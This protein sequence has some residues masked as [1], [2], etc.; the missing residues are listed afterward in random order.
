MPSIG[1]TIA[2]PLLIALLAV[3]PVASLVGC[4]KVT[5]PPTAPDPGPSGGGGGATVSTTFKGTAA[6]A[7]NNQSAADGV[8]TVTIV[9]PT[10]NPGSPSAPMGAQA[11]VAASG[12]MI[13]DGGTV[14][15]TGTYDDQTNALTLSGGGY[16]FSGGQ[17]GG[18]LAGNFSGPGATGRFALYEST[19]TNPVSVLCGRYSRIRRGVS[20]EVGTLNFV[21]S[22]TNVTAI[23]VNWSGQD[24]RT[25][26]GT[27]SNGTVIT[28]QNPQDP[29]GPP[30][31]TGT[32]DSGSGTA[33]GLYW[34][35]ES[36]ASTWRAGPC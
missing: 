36:Q 13:V 15:L 34:D 29:S 5:L 4:S 6:G 11:A 7:G 18:T 23:A 12:T 21:I 2:R 31:I 1:S 26:N 17:S 35:R 30:L 14:D 33:T 3:L 32:F 25:L 9:T 8:L 28:I 27:L 24:S 10:P 16:S 22:G 20:T 19:T